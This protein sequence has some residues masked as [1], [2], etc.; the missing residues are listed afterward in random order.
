MTRIATGIDVG[1]STAV[2]LRGE[3]KGSSFVVTHFA[4][5]P[6]PAG[7]VET[8]WEA[9]AL[10]FKPGACRVGLTGRDVNVRYTRVPRVPDWQL[11]KLMRFEAEEVGGQSETAV[12][13]DF[14]VLP[15]MPEIEGEDVVLL[16]MAREGLLE[17]HMEGLAG[18]G[19]KLDAFTPNAIALYNAFLHYGV[20]MD[21]TV[22][23]ASVGRE[24]TDV[25]LVRGADLV[26]AR[27]LT[28]GS[29]LFDEALAQRFGVSEA[30]AE[31]IK[32]DLGTLEPDATY[33]DANHEKA[34]RA[35]MGPAG[36]I[37]S[38]LQS[39]VMFCKS[40]VK[41]S[42]LKL[43]RV[44]VCG[45]GVALP[46][47][48]AYLSR[49][50]GVPVEPFDP[51]LVV[52]V[53]KLDAESADLLEDHRLEAVTALGLATSASDPESYAIEILPAQVQKR[54]DFVHGTAFLIAAAALAV[55]YLGLYAW[56]SSQRL[57]ESRVEMAA[58]ESRHRKAKRD[59]QRAR[60]LMEENRGLAQY[61]SQLFAIA[62]SGE[63]MVRTL[64]VV[65][66][67]L[68]QGFW[69]DGMT[70]A[71]GSDDELGVARAEERPILRIKGRARE[72]T[73]APAL[74]FEEFVAALRAALPE[75]R[76]KE[77]MGSTS[78]DFTLDLTLLAPAEPERAPG[79]LQDT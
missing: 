37:L 79:A 52:D 55:V 78:S 12:A 2:A 40:Q 35:L 28:G 72:G 66:R 68:P 67:N 71:W 31:R 5:A 16:C 57:A 36:Q 33:R 43:D 39:T 27:N 38:L 3:V 46:G 58:L 77:R 23:I 51:F 1:S 63:Q 24:N 62:G 50:L 59:D 34:S 15:E 7:T 41:L 25:V 26:F 60:A 65:E 13:S 48:D 22:L 64:D 76:I 17:R 75:A 8:G 21:D 20:V 11:K 73:D 10:G 61:A 4:V 56:R 6:N 45:G 69:L 70:S 14:N 19:G 32:I 49:G 74:L 18:S 30:K 29:R 9:L 53:S 42:N 54:R 44:L 47:L